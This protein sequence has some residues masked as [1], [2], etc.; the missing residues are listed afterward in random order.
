MSQRARPNSRFWRWFVTQR[1]DAGLTTR[2][3]TE[4]GKDRELAAVSRLPRPELRLCLDPRRSAGADRGCADDRGFRRWHSAAP[5]RER[6]GLSIAGAG[7]RGD[8]RR[9]S[10]GTDRSCVAIDTVLA[11][12]GRSLAGGDGIGACGQAARSDDAGDWLRH[13]GTNLG[14]S[15][16]VGCRRW[17][18]A[19]PP[20]PESWLSGSSVEVDGFELK[21]WNQ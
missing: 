7:R 21:A 19:A 8:R 12:M 4:D 16:G 18:M 5:L 11:V 13:P 10:P 20:T 17:G 3:P 15:D 2:L 6:G 9:P 14:V 1:D